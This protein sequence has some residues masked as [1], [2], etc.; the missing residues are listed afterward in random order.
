MVRL[1][2]EENPRSLE[3]LLSDLKNDVYPKQKLFIESDKRIKLFIGGNR[4]GKTTSGVIDIVLELVGKHPL[5]IQGKRPFP[6]LYWR[7][8]AP[9]FPT[10]DKVLAPEFIHWLP[11]DCFDRYDS[12]NKILYCKQDS[13]AR[14]SKID[15]LSYEQELEKFGAA[16][17][18]G[19]MLDEEPPED[20]YNESL[21]RL[22]DYGG[23]IVICMTPIK[24]MSW[25][26]DR[27]WLISKDPDSDIFSVKASIWD[28]PYILKE[29]KEKI[30][31]ELQGDERKVREFGDWIEFAG[32]VWPEF[33]NDDV[34]NGGHV[35]DPF[36]L[37]K[38]GTIYM[39]IDPMDRT[40]AVLWLKVLPS[41][42]LIFF[43][44]LLVDDLLIE[45][46]ARL[47][48]EK[49]KGLGGVEDSNRYIDWNASREDPV[50]GQS[51]LAEY[52]K[53]PYN[54][55]C[56]PAVKDWVLGKS[57]GKE[58]WNARDTDGKPLCVVFS[59]L[60]HF[61][62][63][64]VHYVHADYKRDR[65]QRNLPNKPKKRDDHLPD[66]ARYLFA[67]RPGY[68]REE[69]NMQRVEIDH[70]DPMSA[71]IRRGAM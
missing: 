23:R 63:Q 44:E 12:R 55:C 64:L 14:G 17:R 11:K 3:R 71:R 45:D 34:K 29:E 36:P 38:E 42:R 56:S 54:I 43:D 49:E 32:L 30:L 51:V 50:S 2:L 58:Y 39:A 26:F 9:D 22:I 60:K 19:L 65:E 1:Y 18:H 70:L 37:P 57:I 25:I 41:G 52:A 61:R 20:V 7:A 6:P 21:M 69:D 48:S 16:K 4:S 33:K 59:T 35:I 47:I 31:K 28:N 66:C 8:C 40:Q 27:I 68:I 53:S 5:Q 62:R 10:I 13:P 15:F 46:V 24:G 67:V